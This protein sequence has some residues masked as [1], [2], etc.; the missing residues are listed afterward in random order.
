MAGL[1]NTMAIMRFK[2]LRC[3]NWQPIEQLLTKRQ[4]GILSNTI[5]ISWTAITPLASFQ[6]FQ[7]AY[8]HMGNA[9]AIGYKWANER[10]DAWWAYTNIDN[11]QTPPEALTSA[12]Q[13]LNDSL[14]SIS[15]STPEDYFHG[16]R[17][18]VVG[19]NAVETLFAFQRIIR[20]DAKCQQP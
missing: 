10:K 19:G 9:Q 3:H 20:F 13:P 16:M 15:S 7:S 8:R 2:L 4:L 6:S 18:L 5:H 14:V 1:S 12:Q 17:A 11:T